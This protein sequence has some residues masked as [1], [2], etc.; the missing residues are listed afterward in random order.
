MGDKKRLPISHKRKLRRP[1]KLGRCVF[2][3]KR[4]DSKRDDDLWCPKCSN[5]YPARVADPVLT[6]IFGMRTDRDN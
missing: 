5:R 4:L 6:V 1:D 2:C 3:D